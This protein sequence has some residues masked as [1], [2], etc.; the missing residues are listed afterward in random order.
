MWKKYKWWKTAW[1]RVLEST[2]VIKADFICEADCD[3][4]G[5]ETP[6]Q[7]IMREDHFVCLWYQTERIATTEPACSDYTY[8]PNYFTYYFDS[9]HP[10]WLYQSHICLSSWVSCSWLAWVILAVRNRTVVVL[11]FTVYCLFLFLP[12]TPTSGIYWHVSGPVKSH[13]WHL[14]PPSPSFF[15]SSFHFYLDRCPLRWVS[16][17]PNFSVSVSTLLSFRGYWFLLSI[18]SSTWIQTG[19]FAWLPINTQNIGINPLF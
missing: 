7:I 12:A 16:L 4:G 13:F 10:G 11:L 6:R 17:S 5:W 18:R 1:N 3:S 2:F 19:Q 15:F 9:S 14:F 8:K